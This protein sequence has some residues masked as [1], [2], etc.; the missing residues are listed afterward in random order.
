MCKFRRILIL[1]MKNILLL[2]LS[3]LLFYSCGRRTSLNEEALKWQPYKISDSLVFKSSKGESFVLEIDTI[4]QYHSVT[5]P[6]DIIP[7]RTEHLSVFGEY[8]LINPFISSIGDSV[9]KESTKLLHL[10]SGLEKSNFHFDLIIEDSWYYGDSSFDIID[11]EEMKR[12]NYNE[13]NDV[14]IFED[15]NSEYQERENQI[16]RFYWSKEFGYYRYE[17]KNGYWW[18]LESFNREGENILPTN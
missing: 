1:K 3:I 14:L 11:L 8:T 13:L 2:T 16:K 7:D 12:T 15:K 4:I 18:Q 5:D 6:L 17:L 10:N 9:F